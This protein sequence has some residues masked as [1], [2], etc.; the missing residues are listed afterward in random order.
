VEWEVYTLNTAAPFVA[1]A[2]VPSDNS[3]TRMMVSRVISPKGVLIL[4][5]RLILLLFLGRL[6][7]GL[8]RIYRL[9]R[10]S[11]SCGEPDVRIIGGEG[12]AFTFGR[13]VY[14]SESVYRAADFDVILAH[15]RA[16]AHQWHT[17]DALFMEFFRAVFWFHPMAWWMRRQVQL[18]LEYLADAAVLRAG[19]DR[20]AYQLSL[21]A[22]QHGTDFRTSI[23]PQFAAQ[24]LKRR[25][26]MMSFRA[27]PQVRSLVA[28]G[29]VIFMGFVAFACTAGEAELRLA[30]RTT[31]WVNHKVPPSTGMKPFHD[32]VKVEF[33]LFM[34][35]LP[36]PAEVEQIRPYLKDFFLHDIYVYQDCLSPEGHFSFHLSAWQ[37]YFNGFKSW[38]PGR[39]HENPVRLQLNKDGEGNAGRTIFRSMPLPS[40]APVGD[41]LLRINNEWIPIEQMPDQPYDASSIDGPIL[42]AQMDCLLGLT[43]DNS[44]SYNRWSSFTF[45]ETEDN[46]GEQVRGILAGSDIND[47]P[48][49]YH[50]NGKEVT[51][52]FL[53]THQRPHQVSLYI[54]ARTEGTED[55]AVV[56]VVVPR[57]PLPN[58]IK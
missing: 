57:K 30:E 38:E 20:R 44:E 8:F 25:I 35:R 19:Y 18:N 7:F 51:E 36:T 45:L 26:K 6:L 48:V 52:D 4:G 46:V 13:T 50:L 17:I 21:V 29:G 5:Y 40:D 53:S 3:T 54:A 12:E 27:G 47:I 32:G 33:D 16:H 37:G 39:R 31:E 1:V 49:I 14:V 58:E 56:N 22:H 9:H 15:E 28:V 23:L 42:Y 2:D 10:G 41:V 34:K 24:G 55:L 11:E 43:P